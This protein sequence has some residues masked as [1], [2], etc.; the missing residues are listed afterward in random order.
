MLCL[1]ACTHAGRLL[2]GAG[3]V[4]SSPAEANSMIVLSGEKGVRLSAHK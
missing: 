3:P 2:T 1:T 4:I